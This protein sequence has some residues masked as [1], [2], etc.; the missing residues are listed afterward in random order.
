MHQHILASLL[1][2]AFFFSTAVSAQ[3]KSEDDKKAAPSVVSQLSKL[4]SSLQD[5]IQDLTVDYRSAKSEVEKS[6]VVSKRRKIEKKIVSDAI[7]LMEKRSSA[8]RNINDL[9]WYVGKTKED[10]R[11]MALEVLTKKYIDDSLLTKLNRTLLQQRPAQE[12]EDTFR[13]VIKKT[14]NQKVEAD[15]TLTLATYLNRINDD[16]EYANPDNK[17]LSSKSAEELGEEVESL[18]KKCVEDFGEQQSVRRAANRMLSKMRIRIG[19]VAPDIVGVDLDNK[20][21][22]LS[23]YRGKV[24]V[25]D[26]WGDW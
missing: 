12:I 3:E 13:M 18:L 16:L 19:S 24:V 2:V 1:A 23:D 8:S 22:K 7:E 9:C 26:F 21:F 14:S 5:Q 25:L 6:E 11:D 4:R 20:E 15:A 17:Y 10:A